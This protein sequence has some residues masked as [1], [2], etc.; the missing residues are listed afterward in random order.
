[1]RE[2]G[3]SIAVHVDNLLTDQTV[4]VKPLARATSKIPGMLGSAV[5]GSGVPLLILNPMRMRS[6]YKAAA[7]MEEQTTSA[8]VVRDV[9][10]VMVVD[11]SLTVRKITEK[12]LRREGFDVL[13]AVDGVDAVEKLQEHTPDIILTDI[14]MPRMNGFELTQKLRVCD[15]T[16]DVPIIMISSR[17]IEKHQSHAK[18]LGVNLY[19]GKPYQEAVLLEHVKRLLAEAAAV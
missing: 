1:L 3:E 5:S 10:L 19:L 17:A 4:I 11:D 8:R 18:E 16:K 14:E 13:T 9:P 7:Q 12:F 6:M 2:F 15:A